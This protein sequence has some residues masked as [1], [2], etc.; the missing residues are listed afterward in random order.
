MTQPADIISI[1][2]DTERRVTRIV[3]KHFSIELNGYSNKVIKDILA[4]LGVTV[5]FVQSE[6]ADVQSQVVD[7]STQSA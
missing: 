4:N 1:T 2:L 6:T 7:E 3:G 5:H